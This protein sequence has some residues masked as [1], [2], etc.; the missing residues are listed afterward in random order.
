MTTKLERV[1]FETFVHWAFSAE[2]P[3]DIPTVTKYKS[4]FLPGDRLSLPRAVAEVRSAAGLGR[5]LTEEG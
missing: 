2:I 3:S 5:R 1:E 4:D